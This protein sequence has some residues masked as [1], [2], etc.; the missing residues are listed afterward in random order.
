MHFHATW[1]QWEHLINKTD[2]PRG[3]DLTMLTVK[4][5]GVF[6]GDVLTLFRIGKNWWGEGD[7]KIF[8]DEEDF[9][10]H[11]GTGS[12]DYFGYAWCNPNFFETPYFAQP[13]GSG[14]RKPGY[15]VNLRYRGLDAIPFTKAFWFDREFLGSPEVR[16]NYAP[17]AFFYA[18]PGATVEPAPAPQAA[19]RPVPTTEAEYNTLYGETEP[20]IPA[21]ADLR[22]QRRNAKTNAKE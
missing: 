18:R 20:V 15:V 8:V 21:D 17:T 16:T 1:K 4:G 2:W 10:S 13:D 3:Y 14:A 22:L 7:E 11:F 5:R 6:V 19:A 12:E 9:P